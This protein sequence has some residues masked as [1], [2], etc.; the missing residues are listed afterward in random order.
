MRMH[1]FGHVTTH[2]SFYKIRIELQI[3]VLR[4]TSIR[5]SKIHSHPAV[6]G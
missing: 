4:L 3:A 1:I 6:G 5:N 2:Y